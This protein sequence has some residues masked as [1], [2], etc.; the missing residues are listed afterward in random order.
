MKRTSVP[1]WHKGEE[2]F[3]LLEVLL[4]IVIF[5]IGILAVLGLQAVMVKHSTEA[6]MR[7]VASL[8][9]EERISEMWADPANAINK[10]ENAT[11]IEPILPNGTR[12]VVQLVPGRYQIT[13]GWQL[14][15]QTE[16]HRFVT[17]ANVTGG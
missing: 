10:L 3:L 2:G 8:V 16:P 7:S 11:N 12:T 17:V 9:A 13:V 4:A 15:G 1:V 5:S 14:P 6:R